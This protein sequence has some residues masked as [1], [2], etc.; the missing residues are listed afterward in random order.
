MSL[1]SAEGI[2]SWPPYLPHLICFAVDRCRYCPP[3]CIHDCVNILFAILLKHSTTR[4]PTARSENM[5]ERHLVV[6]DYLPVLCCCLE[7]NQ[8]NWTRVSDILSAPVQHTYMHP[9]IHT[10]HI[11][12][13]SDKPRWFRE[14]PSTVSLFI[15]R[16]IIHIRGVWRD[17]VFVGAKQYVCPND[18]HCME[19]S[20]LLIARPRARQ[21]ARVWLNQNYCGCP[22][23][24]LV[25]LVPKTVIN[26][27]NLY[28]NR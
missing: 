3:P 20:S 24:N 7:H 16:L 21:A 25:N 27:D 4:V 10:I 5:S 12:I 9:T 2:L 19:W 28:T 1:P 17:M 8:L 18:C 26:T 23:G 15:K 14:H 22:N 11:N 13:R 6:G